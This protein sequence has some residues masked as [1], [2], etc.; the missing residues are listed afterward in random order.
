MKRSKCFKLK[1]LIFKQ[2][3]LIYRISFRIK[4]NIFYDAHRDLTFRIE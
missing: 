4:I 3:Q 2:N 1:R